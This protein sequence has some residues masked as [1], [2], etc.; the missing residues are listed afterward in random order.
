M[1]FI[2]F[3]SLSINRCSCDFYL[4]CTSKKTR[5]KRQNK[6]SF[7]QKCEKWYSLSPTKDSTITTLEPDF[8]MH[9]S[10]TVIINSYWLSKFLTLPKSFLSYQRLSKIFHHA[11]F[12]L[13]RV[14]RCQRTL[15]FPLKIPTRQVQ[16]LI[17][18]LP[19]VNLP[20]TSARTAELWLTFGF[21]PQK[22]N[23]AHAFCNFCLDHLLPSTAILRSQS[24]WALQGTA[25]L[26]P[27]WGSSQVS[28]QS[29]SPPSIPKL[30][31]QGSSVRPRNSL[32]GNNASLPLQRYIHLPPPPGLTCPF[33]AIC[34]SAEHLQAAVSET[35]TQS[36]RRRKTFKTS[37]QPQHW[38]EVCTICS[39]FSKL[40]F[41]EP[42]L[43]AGRVL[44]QAVSHHIPQQLTSCGYYSNGTSL[45]TSS[46]KPKIVLIRK[47]TSKTFQSLPRDLSPQQLQLLLQDE[48]HFRFLQQSKPT[49]PA[50]LL[51]DTAEGPHC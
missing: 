6:Y 21:A 16:V 27:S 32:F 44:S 39:A 46:R 2:H 41:H 5:I 8:I 50:Q 43:R 20:P 17:P 29:V 45:Y 40:S 34:G 26:A 28:V 42:P 3:H 49:N 38:V 19:K 15:P 36:L 25:S 31:L 48:A 1:K 9:N 24:L 10:N 18:S 13:F 47:R 12:T 11:L 37:K 4:N 30:H 35:L 22:L 51:S 23:I 33:T 7:S 14:R